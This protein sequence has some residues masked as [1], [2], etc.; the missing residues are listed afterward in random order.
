MK[1]QK[2]Y[3]EL[4]RRGFT[5]VELLVV[6]AI[7]GLLSTLAVVSLGNIREKGRDTK[8]INTIGAVQKAMD[9]VKNEQGSYKTKIGCANKALVKDC[10]GGKLEEKLPNLKN[11]GDPSGTISCFT[12]C[13][14][15]CEP[16]FRS[17]GKN[18]YRVDFYLENGAGSYDEPGCYKLNQTGITKI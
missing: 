3:L 2:A 17:I 4:S 10:L 6:I 9:L 5:L 15:P 12:K 1:K 14:R 11:L 7:I 16:V 18:G 13:D 8:R